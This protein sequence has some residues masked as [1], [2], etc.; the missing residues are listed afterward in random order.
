V[1]ALPQPLRCPGCPRKPP[2]VPGSCCFAIWTAPSIWSAVAWAEM[3]RANTGPPMTQVRRLRPII[4]H[5]WPVLASGGV[6]DRN[7]TVRLIAA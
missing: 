6:R 7:P 5:S 4:G 1:Q 3:T 2:R